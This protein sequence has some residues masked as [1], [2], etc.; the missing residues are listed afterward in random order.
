MLLN[1]GFRHEQ[2]VQ[3]YVGLKALTM[4]V[5][6]AVATPLVIGRYGMSQM[7]LLYILLAGALGFYL[8]GM[9]VGSIRRS[10]P[11]RSSSGS[12]TRST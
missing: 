8:P 5:F 6:L 3:I 7:G 4:L 12:P 1:A 9:V 10:G 11:R 2:A